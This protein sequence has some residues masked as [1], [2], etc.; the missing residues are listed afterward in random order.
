MEQTY[1]TISLATIKWI[2]FKF[3][4]NT[5]GA[6]S[7]NLRDFGEL[8]TNKLDIFLLFAVL[9]YIICYN[10]INMILKI[11]WSLVQDLQ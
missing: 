4:A 6:Q 7:F 1:T 11:Q 8:L 2:D 10:S 5:L 9:N 3:G